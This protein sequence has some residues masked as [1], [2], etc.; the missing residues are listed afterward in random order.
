[1]KAE[2]VIHINVPR[3]VVWSVTEDIERWPE[4]TPTVASINRLDG[5]PFRVGSSALI[6][7]PGLPE[8][9]WVVTEMSPGSRFTWE[10]RARGIRMMASHELA[11]SGPGTE[12]LLRLEMSGLV[13]ALLWP[14]I[15]S[16]VRRSLEREN[17][18]LKTR[19]EAQSE[20]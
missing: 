7:Q 5:G 9:R 14:L 17:S 3:S 19:S 13:A 1:M 10:T 8:A 15:R 4:W 11:D 12:S 16:S 20:P 2:N 18:G 6:K